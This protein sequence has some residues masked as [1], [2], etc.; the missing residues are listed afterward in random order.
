[1][2]NY[3]KKTIVSSVIALL[4][5]GCASSVSSF[6]QLKEEG[7]AVVSDAKKYAV[8]EDVFSNIRYSD[9]FFVPELKERD[10]DK[11][12]WFIEPAEGSFLDYTLEEIM[13]DELSSKG[14]NIRYLD[15]LNR[16]KPFSPVH[17]GTVGGLLDK[18]SFA[19]KYSYEIDGDLLTWSKY[20]TSE[21]D[22]AF[23]AGQTDYLFGSKAEKSGGAGAGA[24]G[25]NMV[26]TE[27]GFSDSD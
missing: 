3:F 8:S 14:I 12:S 19:T 22:V 2:N 6:K 18:I 20:K 24:T 27:S 26:V 13:R 23:I 21:F 16:S 4:V 9:D 7:E 15:S 10:Q 11:P 1:M 25:A 17:K 5:V